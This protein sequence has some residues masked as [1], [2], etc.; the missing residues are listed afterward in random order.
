MNAVLG[1]LVFF[2]G[3][4]FVDIA[5]DPLFQIRFCLCQHSVWVRAPVQ[6]HI[7]FIFACTEPRKCLGLGYKCLHC[8]VR[9]EEYLIFWCCIKWLFRVDTS[10]C[11]GARV[12]AA[13]VVA[14]VVTSVSSVSHTSRVA[15][16]TLFSAVRIVANAASAR[17]LWALIKLNIKSQVIFS[18]CR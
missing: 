16:S 3:G 15:V 9:D 2:W 13:G 6:A 10:T 4:P 17:C 14:G 5:S 12:A 8:A 18:E 11:C 7:L 1:S